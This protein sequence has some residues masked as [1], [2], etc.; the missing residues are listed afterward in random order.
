M[1][2]IDCAGKELATFKKSPNTYLSCR[3]TAFEIDHDNK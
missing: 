3:L 1:D 2:K